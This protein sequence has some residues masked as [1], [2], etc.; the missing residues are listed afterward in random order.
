[1]AS[2][3][4]LEAGWQAT[5]K[6]DNKPLAMSA[7][8]RTWAQGEGGRVALRLVQGLLLPKDVQSCWG[9]NTVGKAPQKTFDIAYNQLI[10]N[11][12]QLP[13]VLFLLPSH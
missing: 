13:G 3:S 10:T 5:F 4:R 7:S 1:M 9:V 6:L 11:I 12:E 8:V 2:S